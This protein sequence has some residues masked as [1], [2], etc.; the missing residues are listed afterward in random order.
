M[1][2]RGR[3]RPRKG[4]PHERDAG[5]DGG[6]ETTRLAHL[7][8]NPPDRPLTRAQ[9]QRAHSHAHA[10]AVDLS[11]LLGSRSGRQNGPK[12]R[13]IRLHGTTLELALEQSI[14]MGQ[15]QSGSGSGVASSSRGTGSHCYRLMVHIGARCAIE[16]VRAPRV[17]GSD[18]RCSSTPPS[19]WP[20]KRQQE[21]NRLSRRVR[22]VAICTRCGREN[23]DGFRFCGSCGAA[24]D[25][26]V[27]PTRE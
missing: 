27:F 4:G 20:R 24:V 18:H 22:G 15:F 25:A 7:R 21:R 26:A 8:P 11:A 9:R 10:P 16:S 23:P 12:L 1:L 14:W 6:R 13:N 19:A 3:P 17:R 5:R 2:S